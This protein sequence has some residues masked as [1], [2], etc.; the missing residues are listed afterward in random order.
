MHRS[1]QT[2]A[3]TC[4]AVHDMCQDDEHKELV[5]Q[6]FDAVISEIFNFNNTT[7]IIITKL[8]LKAAKMRY[9]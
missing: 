9:L 1:E 8:K 2:G 7:L 3:K 6:E 5:T 4:R